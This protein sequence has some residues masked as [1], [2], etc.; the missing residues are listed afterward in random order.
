MADQEDFGPLTELIGLWSSVHGIN[1]IA[2]PDG[3][4]PG[5]GDP[6]MPPG[7]TFKAN[8]YNEMV[9]R[10]GPLGGPVPNRAVPQAQ[11]IH[12]L[13]YEQRISQIAGPP[14]CG[15]QHVE[16]GLWMWT[17]PQNTV[18]R[19]TSVPHGNA[20]LCWGK[21]T[22][23]EGQPPAI[24]D[25]DFTPDVGSN[26]PPELANFL[27]NWSSPIT[28]HGVPTGL[29]PAH[30]NRALIS[31]VEEQ[32]A[33]GHT[34]GQVVTLDVSTINPAPHP[35]GISNIEFILDNANATAVSSTFWIE[36]VIP[37]SGPPFRQ[38]QY[39]QTINLTFASNA[40]DPGHGPIIWPHVDVNTLLRQERVLPPGA[41]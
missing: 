26:P 16:D 6:P 37:P 11:T 10:F 34:F 22:V 17:V 18:A 28:L 5:G 15:L 24:P 9:L 40:N 2:L 20:F 38:L 23:T 33:S 13:E 36:T 1:T 3:T 4:N 32:V 27:T 14:P 29:T 21:A 8:T 31:V 12:A 39:S 19:S 7:I 41:P 30:L 25:P 35:G